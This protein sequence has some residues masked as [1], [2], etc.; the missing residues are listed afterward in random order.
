M[1][2]HWFGVLLFVL[3][4]VYGGDVPAAPPWIANMEG[5]EVDPMAQTFHLSEILCGGYVAPEVL[6][7]PVTESPST[8]WDEAWELLLWRMS[9]PLGL[10]S[11]DGDWFRPI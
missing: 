5:R 6:T 4:G 7:K 1:K 3:G 8:K 10:A 11:E 9:M 2:K